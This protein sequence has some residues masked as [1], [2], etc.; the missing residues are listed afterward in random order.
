ML[1]LMTVARAQ[2][3]LALAYMM[4]RKTMIGGI[5]MVSL[6]ALFVIADGIPAIRISRPARTW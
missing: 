4:V 6:T 2:F 5:V 1:T 3:R